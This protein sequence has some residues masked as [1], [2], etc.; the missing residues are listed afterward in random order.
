MAR[1]LAAVVISHREA[2]RSTQIVQQ[3]TENP[4]SATTTR[5][6][7]GFELPLRVPLGHAI[8]S[9]CYAE[10]D[11]KEESAFDKNQ[12]LCCAK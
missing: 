12:L 11:R 9:F 10:D 7:R 4:Y 8:A 1:R 6:N 3:D 5:S 2:K